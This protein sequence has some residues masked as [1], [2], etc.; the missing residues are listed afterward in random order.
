MTLARRLF[1]T[2]LLASATVWVGCDGDD[3]TEPVRVRITGTWNGTWRTSPTSSILLTSISMIED[4]SGAVSDNGRGGFL[5]A[6]TNNTGGVP[7][8]VEITI[9]NISLTSTW[10]LDG[11]FDG[12]DAIVGVVNEVNV[13]PSVCPGD[14]PATFTRLSIEPPPPR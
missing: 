12:V 7:D 2:A 14:C 10:R 11:T 8:S 1:A 3:P 4:N 13:V 6:G 5:V 9:T